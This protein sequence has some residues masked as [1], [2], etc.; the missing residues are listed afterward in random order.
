[1]TKAP[2]ETSVYGGMDPELM[3]SNKTNIPHRM[4]SRLIRSLVLEHRNPRF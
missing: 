3:T 2:T 4:I 1:M